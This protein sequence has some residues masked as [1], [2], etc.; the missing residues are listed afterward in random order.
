MTSANTPPSTRPD[1]YRHP[2][3]TSSVICARCDRPICTDCMIQASVG[4]QCPECVRQGVKTSRTIQPFAGRG[5]GRSGIVGSTNPTPMV[6]AL[7]AVNVVTF[8]ASGF[9]KQSVVDRFGGLSHQ[10]IQSDQYYRFLTAMFLHLSFFHIASNMITLLIVGP[11]VEVML[12][13]SRFV[14]LFLLAGLGGSTASYLFTP[15]NSVSAGASGAIFGV[16]GAY[17]ILAH[18]RRQ[19]LAQVV[20]LIAI[21]LVIGFTGNIDWRDHLGGLVIGV[22]VA[23]AYDHAADLRHASQRIALLAGSS[24]GVLILLAVLVKAVPPGHI[25]LEFG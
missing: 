15:A 22:V 5:L 14:A 25:L 13:R 21:N 23:L 7:I 16:L 12:G 19:P 17:V 11:A 8:V 20:A 24:A 2:G 3:R 4:W 10:V 18:R 6:I 1:C 9:G